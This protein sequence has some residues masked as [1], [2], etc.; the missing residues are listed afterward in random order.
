MKLYKKWID[1]N[2]K[3][4]DGDL[5]IVTGADGSIG[6]FITYYLIYLGAKVVMAVRD[7]NKANNLK[8][9]IL[10]QI[11]N[12]VIYVE[13]LDLFNI[14]SIKEAVP[15]LEKY[16]PKYLINNAGVYHLPVMKNKEGIERTFCINF[17]GQY[18][19]TKELIP[20]IKKN[21]GK[22]INQC[23]IST[24]WAKV[25]KL[26]FN[27]LNFDNEKNLTQKYAKTKIAMILATLKAKEA[28]ID[29]VLVHPGASATSLFSSSRGGFS[30]HFDRIIMP[31]MKLIF[32]SPSKASL[33]TLFALN[34][35]TKFDEWIGPRGLFH[36]WGYP[37]VSKI[38]KEFLSN[39]LIEE[40]LKNLRELEGKTNFKL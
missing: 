10:E 5:A 6:Y 21:E 33:S 20:V 27:D 16:N 23:S 15:I 32:I 39:D 35:D 14:N 29:M 3:R 34:H 26:N 28:G 11:P 38:K 22:I 7:I 2:V 1:K 40:F 19:A 13:H 25:K 8:D 18:L 4:L 36:I 24:T 17:Y 9:K 37:K 31:L 30:K 12:G